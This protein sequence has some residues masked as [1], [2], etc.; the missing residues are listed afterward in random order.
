[1]QLNNKFIKNILACYG[2]EGQVWLDQLYVYI[3]SLASQW[4]FNMLRPVENLSYNFVAEVEFQTK[5][6]ILK[7]VPKAAYQLMAEVAW[8]EAHKKRTPVIF[9][10]SSEINACL[11]EKL[12][13]GRSLKQLVK[14]GKD[15]EA[16]RILSQ[17]ILDLQSYD[18]L[19]Q[20]SYQPLSEH[21]A[22]FALLRGYIDEKIID[23][24]R[25][26]FTELC[27]DS[28]ND[29]ILH[30]DLHHDN[31]LQQGTSWYVI[32]PPGYVGD[33]CA[34][35]GPLLY[36]PL[37]CFPEYMLKKNTVKRR[38]KILEEMLP[39]DIERIKAWGFC[40]A[41]RSAA[42]DVEGFGKPDAHTIEIAKILLNL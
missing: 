34:E 20:E 3:N 18:V 23:H 29:I 1:M 24:A 42:W 16:T 21:I 15:D 22:A 36:N 13:P 11:M 41:L 2:K 37:D 39:F 27:A 38:L 12:E 14:E 31:I 10:S 30:G 4:N 6:A 8:L 19:H 35:I 25:A 26:V 28:S 40:L 5:I 7:I 9:H 17:V 32:D 33:P